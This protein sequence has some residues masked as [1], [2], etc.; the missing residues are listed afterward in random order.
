MSEDVFN[1]IDQQEVDQEEVQEEVAEESENPVKD[2]NSRLSV[3]WLPLPLTV[4][5][6]AKMADELSSLRIDISL[7]E[8]KKKEKAD[9]Y[10]SQ[11]KQ[12]ESKILDLSRL[13]REG[14]KEVEVECECKWNFP[15][16]GIVSY[17]NV[18]GELIFDR[19]MTDPEIEAQ[20]E[21][22][23]FDDQ[24]ESEEQTGDDTLFDESYEV[25]EEEPT[26]EM[27]IDDESELS[28]E[29][30]ES[31][32]QSVEEAEEAIEAEAREQ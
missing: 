25:I 1:E 13:I 4:E 14:R 16:D 12:K 19:K 22:S 2:K 5:Q 8:Q 27:T 21:P 15:K 23:M 31:P 29:I 30:E 3:R 6:K 10:N 24:P 28:E 9:A 18:E 26:G 11:I 20:A 7:L 17:Y 32:D